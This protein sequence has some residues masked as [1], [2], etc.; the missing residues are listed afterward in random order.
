[1]Q[2]F[3]EQLQRPAFSSSRRQKNSLAAG[4]QSPMGVHQYERRPG[5]QSAAAVH[6][7]KRR[8]SQLSAPT[9]L[10]VFARLL[11]AGE[12]RAAWSPST[13]LAVCFSVGNRA[14]AGCG[15]AILRGR[16]QR[17]FSREAASRR[18]PCFRMALE[19]EEEEKVGVAGLD[20][21][22]LD[23]DETGAPAISKDLRSELEEIEKELD[24]INVELEEGDSDIAG[25]VPSDNILVGNS[26]QQDPPEGIE[27]KEDAQ[28]EMLRQIQEVET[29][30]DDARKD[31]EE[32]DALINSVNIEEDD[33]ED[34]TEIL[35]TDDIE[36][37]HE[38]ETKMPFAT[39]DKDASTVLPGEV[40]EREEPPPLDEED[41]EDDEEED[42]VK[43]YA[44]VEKIRQ[45][46][47]KELREAY[48][49]PFDVDSDL[50]MD[51]DEAWEDQFWWDDDESDYELGQRTPDPTYR[52]RL[53]SPRRAWN[54]LQNVSFGPLI[55]LDVR[56][57]RQHCLGRIPGSVAQPTGVPSP[58]GLMYVFTEGFE[59]EI[60]SKYG[61]EMPLMLYCTYGQIAR[62]VAYRLHLAGHRS[63][64]VVKGG[65]EEWCKFDLPIEE[66]IPDEKEFEGVNLNPQTHE[67]LWAGWPESADL[68]PVDPEWLEQQSLE[69]G[70]ETEVDEWDEWEATVVGES[71]EDQQVEE[72]TRDERLRQLEEL[73]ASLDDEEKPEK[74]DA[75][76]ET[77]ATSTSEDV[78]SDLQVE[79]SGGG[80][81]FEFEDAEDIFEDSPAPVNAMVDTV[82]HAP[83]NAADNMVEIVNSSPMPTVESTVANN[84]VPDPVP[85]PTR[86]KKPAAKKE[87][88][89]KKGGRKRIYSKDNPPVW[90]VTVDA[91]DVEGKAAQ[92]TLTQLS[93]KELKSYLLDNDLTLSGNKPELISRIQAHC[94][95][96]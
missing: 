93:V 49:D 11:R 59:T 36:D 42:H 24:E 4:L 83:D 88:P 91:A 39:M 17:S 89:V 81:E 74:E 44:E 18:T 31:R 25:Y 86:G 58:L 26:R 30:L 85:K 79:T 9:T 76:Q 46:R 10:E 55:C 47:L 23:I 80:V 7:S 50:D 43:K 75:E 56:S 20:L 92:D 19:T 15:P 29:Q 96:R 94:A 82:N 77:N 64:R 84:D 40:E 14:F 13:N 41:P 72:D 78:S 54:L 71:L 33:M 5:L 62:I 68:Q 53:L 2:T 60:I 73:M 63:L 48:K 32:Q 6:R 34:D 61:L 3:T 90:Y 87:A 21:D 57:R 12:A 35:D 52:E 8:V 45:E 1:V 38:E 51:D 70:N 16:S 65:F 37:E 28:E 22:G 27:D 69:D 67:E 95:E 66:G